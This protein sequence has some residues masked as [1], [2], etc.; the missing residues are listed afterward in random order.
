[1]FYFSFVYSI[2]LF[3]CADM[4]GW[5]DASC[6]FPDWL[7]TVTWR[8]LEGQSRYG[9][10]DESVTFFVHSSSTSKRHHHHHHSDDRS[11]F[12]CLQKTAET[13]QQIVVYAF[14][15]HNWLVMGKFVDLL[16]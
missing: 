9:V 4:A 1:V 10:D 13:D 8:D 5:P 11:E 6:R 7:A 12:R 16:S 15:M 14:S 3:A 2:H